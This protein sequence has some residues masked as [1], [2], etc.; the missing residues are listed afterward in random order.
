MAWW[1]V[2]AMGEQR[3]TVEELFA[4]WRHAKGK[5][6]PEELCRDW[7]EF[8]GALKERI[9]RDGGSQETTE[10]MAA[11]DQ[12]RPGA[13][14]G[15]G[16]KSPGVEGAT[17]VKKIAEGGQPTSTIPRDPHK[18]LGDFE[19]LRELG[20]GGMGVVFEAWQVSLNRKVALKV[21]A[22]SLG[23]RHYYCEAA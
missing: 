15:D 6:S 14:P 2:T 18:R 1:E 20:R 21:L 5:A 11:A 23:L 17:S 19:V 9:G 3:P 4:R 16:A 22:G 7:P 13:I 12:G 8:L 10:N